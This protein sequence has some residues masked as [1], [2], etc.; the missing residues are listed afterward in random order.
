MKSN[1]ITNLTI[2]S[3]I[4]TVSVTIGTVASAK[5]VGSELQQLQTA[6][7][8]FPVSIDIVKDDN[9][10]VIIMNHAEAIQYC[11]THDARLPSARELAKLSMSLGSK[12]I[13]D[14]CEKIDKQCGKY[15]PVSI[16]DG[17]PDS[18]YFSSRGYQRPEGDLGKYVFW[19]SSIIKPYVTDF[20]GYSGGLDGDLP[21]S[22]GD[23]GE[24]IIGAVFCVSGH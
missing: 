19:S 20:N 23:I 8:G 11:S 7:I 13:V 21:N 12:G 10:R 5:P 2:F 1:R 9:N 18:F 3:F 6:N 14:A 17:T 22:T 4:F 24:V 16:Y 15:E